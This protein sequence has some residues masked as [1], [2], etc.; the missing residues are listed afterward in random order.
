ML[1][2]HRDQVA[3]F[4]FVELR[5]AFDREVDRLGRARC[6]HNL[7]GV[8]IDEIGDLFARLFHRRLGLPAIRMRA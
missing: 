3:A 5:R 4:V 1:S 8:A 2:F 6:P 7:F